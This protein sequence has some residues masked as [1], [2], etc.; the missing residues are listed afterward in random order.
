[1]TIYR[2]HG[3][4]AAINPPLSRQKTPRREAL[5]YR[6]A[7]LPSPFVT[8]GFFIT[9]KGQFMPGSLKRWATRAPTEQ[10]YCAWTRIGPRPVLANHHC[11][12][13]YLCDWSL[14]FLY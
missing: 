6:C 14:T 2:Q 8:S 10:P 5:Q 13:S 11:N 9:L 1:M 3:E 4:Y 12:T 7:P